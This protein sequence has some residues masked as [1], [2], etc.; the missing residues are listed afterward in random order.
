MVND[1]KR[2]LMW[3]GLGLLAPSLAF[4]LFWLKRDQKSLYLIREIIDGDTFVTEDYSVVRFLGIGAPELG[5]CGGEEAKKHL[6]DLIAGKRVTL[7]VLR[8]DSGGRQLGYAYLNKKMVNQELLKSGWYF[9]NGAESFYGDQL[10]PA[11]YQAKE[12]KLGIYSTKCTQTENLENPKCQIKGNV[13]RSS[14]NLGDKT[15]HFPGCYRYDDV[16]VEL[17]RGDQWF[18]SEKEAQEAG[19]VKSKNCFGKKY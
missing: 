9:Y 14:S 19:F 12:A 10:K 11:Y 1:W 7:E 2:V 8:R 3:L 6:E 17:H 15:Y 16:L 18:C 13:S 5:L 4:N